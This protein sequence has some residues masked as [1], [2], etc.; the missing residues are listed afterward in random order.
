MPMESRSLKVDV[1]KELYVNEDER[2]NKVALR[3]V[4]WNNGAPKLEKRSFYRTRE[5]D[6]VKTGKAVGLTLEDVMLI[7]DHKDEILDLMQKKK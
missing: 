2:G 3:I 5:S 6:E 1:I 4:S 7:L